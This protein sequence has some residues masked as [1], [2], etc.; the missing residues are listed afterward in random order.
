M[1]PS[2]ADSLNDMPA[3]MKAF[4][5]D[6]RRIVRHGFLLV[7]LFFGALGAVGVFGELSGAVVTPGT[8]RVDSYSKKVQHLEGG[9]IDSILVREGDG[10]TAGQV[11]ITLQNANTEA[12]VGLY[13][14]TLIAH[15]RPAYYGQC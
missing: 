6:P 12:S 4:R 8:V 9:I 1:T 11:L 5:E 14:K 7:L 3:T 15:L 13:R 2:P 10:V